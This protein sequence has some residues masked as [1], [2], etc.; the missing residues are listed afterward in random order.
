MQNLKEQKTVKDLM[1]GQD[2]QKAKS[3][4]LPT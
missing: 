3:K 1:I 2:M 4:D